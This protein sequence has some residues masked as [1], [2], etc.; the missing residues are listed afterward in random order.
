MMN[1]EVALAA[2]LF[3]DLPLCRVARENVEAVDKEFS[4]HDE[5]QVT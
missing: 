1:P 5:N 4:I 2:A 3:I